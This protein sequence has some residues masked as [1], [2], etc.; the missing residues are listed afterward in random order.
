M[1]TSQAES[2]RFGAALYSIAAEPDDTPKRRA[3]KT[4]FLMTMV[5]SLPLNL[6]FGIVYNFYSEPVFAAILILL[7]LS[8]ITAL[9]L[10]RSKI[11]NYERIVTFYLGTNLAGNFLGTLSLG[12]IPNSTGSFLYILASPFGMI[13][14]PTSQFV[15]WFGA[16]AGLVMIEAVLQP[17]LRDNNNIPEGVEAVLWGVNF[18]IVAAGLFTNLLA[19]LRQRDQAVKALHAEQ[20][21][22]E[23]L[24]RNILPETIAERLKHKPG[25]I[26]QT[27]AAA[28]VLFADI[29][30]FTPMTTRLKPEDM[31]DLLN[32]IYTAFDRL[33][34]R[35]SVEKIRTI[36]DNYMAACGVPEADPRHAQNI[37]HMALEMQA[38]ASQISRQGT[39]AV[40]FRIGIHSGPLIAGIVGIR[41]FQFDIWGDTVNT[42][43]RME[44]QGRSGKIQVT[45][46]TYE[47]LQDEFILQPGGM[48]E[49]KGKGQMPV[50]FL[51]GLRSTGPVPPG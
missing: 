5:Y 38:Y 2:A 41:K 35:Y 10:L 50:W 20:E 14:R 12:G 6:I 8:T 28:S 18:V 23:N 13:T 32:N 43:S 22:S 7:G 42:A 46:A 1:N 26:V 48:L 29:V 19:L 44:S 3:E 21:R 39:Q 31:I 45:Q 24:L 36:G 51:E 16:A 17:V 25:V 15:R 34:D 49:V 4:Q 37:A 47:L 40:Q 30:G 9:I 11:V 27:H 33:A